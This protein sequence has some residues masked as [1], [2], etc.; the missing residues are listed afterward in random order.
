MIRVHTAAGLPSDFPGNPWARCGLDSTVTHEVWGNLLPKLDETTAAVYA[1]ERSWQA[2][3]MTMQLRGIAVDELARKE[4]IVELKREAKGM[5]KEVATQSA[6]LSGAAI[7]F[8]KKSLAP[9]WQALQKCFYERMAIPPLRNKKGKVSTDAEVLMR[10]GKQKPAVKPICDLV[11]LLRDQQKQIETMETG[12]SPDGR[13]RSQ[14]SVGQTET[15][16]WSATGDC[17]GA[18]LNLQN[19][20][21]RLRHIYIPDPGFEMVNIDLA[22]A[23]SRVIAHLA[24]DEAYIAAHARGNVHVEAGRIFWPA[25]QWTGDNKR[26]KVLMKATPAA[27]AKRMAVKPGKEAA[28]SYYDASKRRQH[29]LN[30]G[31]TPYGIARDE[32]IPVAQAKL[33]T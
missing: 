20:Q 26:D 28:F 31:R 18:G 3:A 10:L 30:Y 5:Q 21:R 9:S 11:L 24:E 33:E 2:M 12:V 7:E 22:Q 4:L 19:Q 13:M 17:Y 29:G 23:E 14:W 1:E 15:G 25:L 32:G 6:A 27:W 8:P 16:R